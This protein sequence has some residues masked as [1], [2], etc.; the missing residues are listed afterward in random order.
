M[1]LYKW[2]KGLRQYLFAIVTPIERLLDKLILVDIQ[3][4]KWYS[5][6]KVLY[7]QF[8]YFKQNNQISSIIYLQN[9]KWH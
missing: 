7:L 4:N 1:L 3:M 5:D 9:E 6:K 8:A 2:G